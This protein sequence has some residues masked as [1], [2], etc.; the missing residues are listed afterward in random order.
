MGFYRGGEGEG[1][2][3][4]RFRRG[5]AR[6]RGE[7]LFGE[8]VAKVTVSK[9]G[10]LNRRKERFEDTLVYRRALCAGTNGRYG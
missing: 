10:I 4:G 6:A 2:R 9:G 3:E 7:V 5:C 8:W 1:E